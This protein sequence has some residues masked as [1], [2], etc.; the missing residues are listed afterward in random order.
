MAIYL[1]YPSEENLNIIV[2]ELNKNIFD[3]IYINFID[4]VDDHVFQGFFSNLISTNK[5]Q[6]IYKISVHP[7][8]FMMYHP[9]LFT[10]NIENSYKFLNSPNINEL[11]F[12]NFYGR[13]GRGLY[14]LLY[15]VKSIP[16][17]KY[18][19]NWFA[20]SIVNV[21]QEN[22]NYLFDKFPELKDDFPRKNNSLLI[23]LDRDTDL[24][25]MLHHSGS[26]GSMLNDLLGISRRKNDSKFEID[27]HVD[28]IWNTYLTMDYPSAHNKISEDLKAIIEQTNFLNDKECN[29]DN[30]G[31][32]SEQINSTLDNMRDI[33][34]K[35]TVLKNHANSAEK[36]S[37]EIR[38]RFLDKF[39]DLEFTLL[40]NRKVT[41]DVYKRLVEVLGLKSTNSNIKN[42]C[43]RLILI[44]YLI[45]NKLSNDELKVIENL[46]TE[47]N[48]S[49]ISFEYLKEKKSFEESLKKDNNAD[50]EFSNG[51]FSYFANKSKNLIKGVS[52]LMS[53]E[54]PSAV[55]DIVK[56][57]SSNQ[58]IN[59]FCSYNL[60]KKCLVENINNNFEQIIVFMVGGG[61][62]AEFEYI[63]QLLKQNH[64]NEKNVNYSFN[65]L[66]NLWVR[67]I[68]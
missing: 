60:L 28:Y 43:I 51:F 36:L 38:S 11:Q 20:N 54:Q 10:L 12:N 59:N 34:I 26:L 65:L 31:K 14:N 8:D 64:K 30:F 29:N 41:K 33:T 4:R 56:S 44:Y 49:K 1:V 46:F 58:T 22:F 37:S 66:G 25:I 9:K 2:N 45:Q 47:F 27:P 48:L 55:A 67:Y 23:I 13:I 5:Y 35:Q 52:S 32:V 50:N 40:S 6:R 68:I 19:Q 24:P 53:H 15:T 17:I 21:I 18:R 39:Y 57:L 3:N 62:L 63:D 42:D 61:S 7:I 16:I